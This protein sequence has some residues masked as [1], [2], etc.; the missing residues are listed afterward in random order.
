MTPV[1]QIPPYQQTVAPQRGGY[2]VVEV[3]GGKDRPLAALYQDDDYSGHGAGALIVLM[4]VSDVG[5]LHEQRDDLLTGVFEVKLAKCLAKAERARAVLVGARD[6]RLAIGERE[7]GA[8][9][10]P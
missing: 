3:C 10:D 8:Q 4:H 6:E 7:V 1:A 9:G 5:L 2:E